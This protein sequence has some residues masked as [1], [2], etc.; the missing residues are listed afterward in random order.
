MKPLR[1]AAGLT[2]AVLSTAI[3][4]PKEDATAPVPVRPFPSSAPSPVE[5]SLAALPQPGAPRPT[6]GVVPAPAGGSAAVQAL[7]EAAP[8][9]GK[10][11]PVA[12]PVSPELAYADPGVTIGNQPAA[13][14]A[15]LAPPDVTQPGRPDL[16]R[17]DLGALT[18]EAPAVKAV[19][20]LY[21]KGEISDGDA[22]AHAVS[23]SAARTLLEWVAIRH[24]GTHVGFRRLSAFLDE[25]GDWPQQD[26]I[27][28][29]A[30]EALWREKVSPEA[31]TAFFAKRS[32]LSAD[33]KYALALAYRADGK[34]KA[35]AALIREAWRHD[36]VDRDLER[37]IRDDF[38]KVLTDDDHRARLE[39]LAFKKEWTAAQRLASDIGAREERL[40]KARMALDRAI[41]PA[42]ALNG[43]SAAERDEPLVLFAEARELRR[44]GKKDEAAK[45]MAKAP[46]APDK[47]IDGDE[48]SQERRR[49]ARGLLDAGEPREAYKVASA[50]VAESETDKIESEVLAGWIALRFLKE[51]ETAAR[52]FAL[53]EPHADLS[54][55]VARVAY[56]R[57][58]AAEAAGKTGPSKKFYE[59]AAQHVTTYYGQLSRARLGLSDL[60]VSEPKPGD[61]M[62]RATLEQRG[63]VQSIRLLYALDERDLATMILGEFA[64]R[65]EGV[66]AMV[67]LSHIATS[68]G[69]PRAELV[70]GKR[71][72]YRGFPLEWAAFPT[73]GIPQFEAVGNSVERSMTYA[74]ARQESAFEA[75]AVSSAGARGL[76]Q[77]MPATAK[78][79]AERAGLPYDVDRLT[80]D[81]AYNAKLGTAHLGDLVAY[82]RGSYIL[83]FAAYNAGPGNVRKWIAAYGDPRSEAVDTVDWV[84]RIPFEETRNYVQRVMENLQVYRH[85]LGDRTALLIE[86]DLHRGSFQ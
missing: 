45:L 56:W 41:D 51:P 67:A 77:L 85:I 30:E 39:R 18:A 54:T 63:I 80:N 71:A 5:G 1:L 79:T 13:Q 69:D 49:L 84:E 26:T 23:S 46:T 70:V 36:P 52:H 59:T 22:A 24:N 72:L 6:L 60:P 32:P 44:R 35:A 10:Q 9:S 21:R 28:Q 16:A 74:I 11:P 19:L 17:P 43:L 66:D 62:V 57:G 37:A 31:V 3:V 20:D 8:S 38:P 83:T 68:L 40:L 55:S 15:S 42:K 7:S 61:M 34:D 75:D 33:G 86:R 48:W 82:W 27:Q 58:R 73:N 65:V 2:V 78:L 14:T 29:Y 53:A 4:L 25:H 64:K 12:K 76:M 81:P 47:V 50:E